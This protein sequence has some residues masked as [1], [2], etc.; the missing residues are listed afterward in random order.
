[1]EM[2]DSAAWQTTSSPHEEVTWGGIVTVS[3]GSTTPRSQ[4]RYWCEIPVFTLCSGMSRMATVVASAPV[5]AVVGTASKGF[6]GEG[7][8]LPPPTGALT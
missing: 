2:K 6:N 3:K 7:G 8:F 1:L 5:P 4:R